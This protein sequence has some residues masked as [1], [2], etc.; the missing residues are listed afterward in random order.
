MLKVLLALFTEPIRAPR[1]LTG[2]EAARLAE[3]YGVKVVVA[4]MLREAK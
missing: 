3:R 2:T 1:T 4:L